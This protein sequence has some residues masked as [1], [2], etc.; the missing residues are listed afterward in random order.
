MTGS[1]AKKARG[2]PKTHGSEI[3]A[4]MKMGIG[5]YRDTKKAALLDDVTWSEWMREAAV[6]R[7]KRKRYQDQGKK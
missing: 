5:L 2:R 7:L 1:K 4:G 6:L 3:N